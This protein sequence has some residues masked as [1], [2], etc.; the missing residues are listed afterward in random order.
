MSADALLSRLT[1]VRPAG[2][3]SWVAC[4]PAHEDRTPSLTITEAADGRVLVHCFAACAVEDVLAAVGLE[5][6]ALFPEKPIT[7]THATPRR[8]RFNAH[9]VLRSVA[10]EIA[11]CTIVIGD[12]KRGE[13]ITDEDLRRFLIAAERVEEAKRYANDPL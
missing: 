9:A 7:D 12:I 11:V 1:K 4:C 8:L 2:A 13:P 3:G 5:F 10:H 6:D